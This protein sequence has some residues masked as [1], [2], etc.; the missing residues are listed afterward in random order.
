MPVT[1]KLLSLYV[2]PIESAECSDSER[3]VVVVPEGRNNVITQAI[4][5]GFIMQ[6]VVESLQRWIV[7]VKASYSS[8]SERSLL[9]HMECQNPSELRAQAMRV[10]HHVCS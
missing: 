4:G 5:G 9:I 6:G 8:D 2:E 10:S 3:P 1:N 7:A